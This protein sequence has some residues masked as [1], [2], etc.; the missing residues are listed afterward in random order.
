M[1]DVYKHCAYS[2]SHAYGSNRG[3]PGVRGHGH[4]SQ[5]A[6]RPLSARCPDRCC[7]GR[8]SRSL[9]GRDQTARSVPQRD[10][11]PRERSRHALGEWNT[12]SRSSLRHQGTRRSAHACRLVVGRRSREL[13]SASSRP[14]TPSATCFEALYEDE[15]HSAARIWKSCRCPNPHFLQGRRGRRSRSKCACGA[16]RSDATTCVSDPCGTRRPRP[17]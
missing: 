14:E 13:R 10:I 9:R 17:R 5:C 3:P 15:Q 2:S 4:V 7:D 1:V 16:S 6:P 11:A 8:R 12:A